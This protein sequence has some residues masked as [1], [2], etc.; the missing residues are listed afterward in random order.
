MI[1]YYYY[2]LYMIYTERYTMFLKSLTWKSRSSVLVYFLACC[3]CIF[4]T[5]NSDH[6]QFN[7]LYVCETS[8]EGPLQRSQPGVT[9]S[10][11][12]H[13]VFNIPFTPWRIEI[14]TPGTSSP[15]EAL[16]RTS[17]FN[18]IS[19]GWLETCRRTV[20]VKEKW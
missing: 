18:C 1:Y 15:C 11:S 6:V 14:W 17:I 4:T 16:K 2:M 8:S 12:S 20:Q 19:S 7:I 3:S 5:D 9:L 10:S 13:S